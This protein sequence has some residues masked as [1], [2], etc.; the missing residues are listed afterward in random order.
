MSARWNARLDAI[1]VPVPEADQYATVAGLLERVAIDEA[2]A[3]MLRRMFGL[4]PTPRRVHRKRNRAEHGS[5]EGLAWHA[6]YLVPDCRP[7]ARYRYAHDVHGTEQ[8]CQA[9]YKD[10]TPLC[11]ACQGFYD[12]QHRRANEISGISCGTPAGN[13]R[14]RRLGERICSSCQQAESRR[15]SKRRV[16]GVDAVPALIEHV[17]GTSSGAAA[18]AGG[19]VRMGEADLAC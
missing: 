14:H 2:D 7:C 19:P 11:D 4:V 1:P 6:E 16:D 9:H 15:E 5:A 8:S 12:D 3:L 18:H 13:R 10:G 17:D